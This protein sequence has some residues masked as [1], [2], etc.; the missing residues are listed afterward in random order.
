MEDEQLPVTGTEVVK[1][2]TAYKVVDLL[3]GDSK[4]RWLDKFGDC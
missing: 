4:E 3:K 2:T 1:T